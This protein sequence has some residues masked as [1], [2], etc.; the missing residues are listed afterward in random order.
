VVVGQKMIQFFG[1]RFGL[2]GVESDM[3]F[4]KTVFSLRLSVVGLESSTENR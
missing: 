4:H 2:R 3:G 1:Q